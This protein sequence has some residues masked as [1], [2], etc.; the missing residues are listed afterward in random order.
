MEHELIIQWKP[1]QEGHRYHVGIRECPET[2]GIL[3]S[4]ELEVQG[5]WT[6]KPLARTSVLHLA[7]N[8][9]GPHVTILGPAARAE[10]GGAPGAE[11]AGVKLK[12][13]A[14][15]TQLMA[16]KSALVS[17]HTASVMGRYALRALPKGAAAAAAGKSKKRKAQEDAASPQDL[18]VLLAPVVVKDTKT[19]AAAE[20]GPPLFWGYC[21]DRGAADAA[22]R[23]LVECRLAVV[24]SLENDGP[25]VQ[26]YT[27]SE[28]EAELQRAVAARED[29]AAAMDQQ[30]QHPQQHATAA[31]EGDGAVRQGKKK[32]RR[33]GL[34]A[35]AIDAGDNDG[36]APA[37]ARLHQS[38]SDVKAHEARVSGY[39][40]LL[41]QFDGKTPLIYNGTTYKP[42]LEKV[43]SPVGPQPIKQHVLRIPAPE[44]GLDAL[45]L[46]ESQRKPMLVRVRQ[47]W[48]EL[49]GLLGGVPATDVKGDAP[50]E[51]AGKA[52]KKAKAGTG[53]TSA[54]DAHEEGPATSEV[55]RFDFLPWINPGRQPDWLM[56]LWHVLD[57]KG[58]VITA[59]DLRTRANS[60]HG[61]TT[62]FG[63]SRGE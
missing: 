47:H 25:L 5:N 36:T 58:E 9:R 23:A 3:S 19:G 29:L 45:V 2:R 1:D 55:P 41:N 53:A 31:G 26:S 14:R 50:A 13:K 11:S 56:E 54:A 6:S 35:T 12:S 38:L 21:L 32:R 57:P 39:L 22:N 49:R 63:A 42:K 24:A 62:R 18:E 33:A 37:V 27:V 28:L 8:G 4:G 44:P 7:S 16:S 52:M 10:T 30:M 46:I 20:D 60:I 61:S 17:E 48:E 43:A 15:K 51:G 40:A 59:D 34:D